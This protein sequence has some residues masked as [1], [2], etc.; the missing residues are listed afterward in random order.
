F[1]LMYF[2]F[3][4]AEPTTGLSPAHPASGLNYRQEN[5][6]YWRRSAYRPVLRCLDA[7]II[8]HYLYKHYK[9]L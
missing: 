5:S 6:A 1:M 7:F 3:P 8:Q 9:H 2:L 4:H